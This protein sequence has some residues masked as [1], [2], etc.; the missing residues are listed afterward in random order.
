MSDPIRLAEFLAALQAGDAAAVRAL[1][2]AEPQLASEPSPQGASPALTALYAGHPALADEV[3]AR[4][5]ELDIFSAAAFDDTGR[6]NDIV[7]ADAAQVAAWSRDG[8]QPLHL[9]S[10]FGRTEAA[11]LLLDSD[12]PVDEP[13]RNAMAVHPLHAAAAGRHSELV[14]LLIASGADVDARQAGGTTALHSACAH[15][16]VESVKALLA[17]GADRVATD[18]DGRDAR[19]LAADDSIRALLDGAG[20]LS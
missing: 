14:W 2:D 4:S 3:A 5:G 17:A 1:L 18:H 16:D 13:S 8:W 11:R 15:G 19:S 6:M 12:A 7:R 9:A 10:F 20:E